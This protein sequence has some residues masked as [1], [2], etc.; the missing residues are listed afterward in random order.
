[1]SSNLR[2]LDPLIT[3]GLPLLIRPLHNQYFALRHG[4]SEANQREII[5]SDPKNGMN[6]YGL[7]SKGA[8][9]VRVTVQEAYDAGILNS[10]TVI[11]SSDFTR[12]QETAQIAR[13]V[14]GCGP[15]NLTPKLRERFFGNWEKTHTS[16]YEKVWSDDEKDFC[17]KKEGVE[18]RAEVLERTL[19][20]II[21]L[22]EQHKGKRFLL[23]SHG[24]PIQILHA[25]FLGK[26]LDSLQQ[27][28]RLGFG[29]IDE[30]LSV[31]VPFKE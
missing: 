22:E 6:M 2:A 28:S 29:E 14:L 15:V 1:M 19:A 24:D 30:L 4:E 10:A 23:V 27:V 3:S 13:Q 16:N 17:H 5:V 21:V 20:L 8:K 31:V 9:Q 18:S 7:T 11:Y 25:Y 26:P 12:T